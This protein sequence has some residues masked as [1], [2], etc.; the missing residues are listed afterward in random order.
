MAVVR[1]APLVSIDFVARNN[2][3]DVLLGKRTNKPAKGYW[4]VPGGRILKGERLSEA[5]KRLSVAEFGNVIKLEDAKPLGVFEHLYDDSSFDDSVG[6]HYVV[7][8]YEVFI[9]PDLS[10][11]PDSQ[12]ADYRWFCVDELLSSE[13]VHDNTKAYFDQDD[14]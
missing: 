13:N 7:I 10:Q 14:V 5:F 2:A 4:F 12:H 6:T 11:L 1:S 8:A 9:D 3:G